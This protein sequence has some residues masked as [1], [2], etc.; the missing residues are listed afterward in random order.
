MVIVQSILQV[1]KQI[2][3][4]KHFSQDSEIWK[5]TLI[6]KPVSSLWRA[7][8]SAILQVDSLQRCSMYGAGIALSLSSCCVLANKPWP[9]ARIA[10]SPSFQTASCPASSEKPGANDPALAAGGLT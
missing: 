5:R 10:R 6:R 9:W 7:G 4:V 8:G 2:T 1:S 3:E